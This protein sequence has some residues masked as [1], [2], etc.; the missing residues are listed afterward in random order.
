[1]TYKVWNIN[2]EPCILFNT[3][4]C[5]DVFDKL[6]CCLHDIR[7]QTGIIPNH[8]V[9]KNEI[10][11]VQTIIYKHLG[12]IYW[13]GENRGAYLGKFSYVDVFGLY[14]LLY[15]NIDKAKWMY[16]F[17]WVEWRGV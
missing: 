10:S 8:F 17:M 14:R 5:Q 3:M 7:E 12:H 6:V 4:K 16:E 1:M 13:A 15:D 2:K 9:K 11:L